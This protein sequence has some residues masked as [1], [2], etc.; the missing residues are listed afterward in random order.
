[1]GPWQK[2]EGLCPQK[3]L[4]IPSRQQHQHEQLSQTD[5]E[6]SKICQC[7]FMPTPSNK[8]KKLPNYDTH[9]EHHFFMPNHFKKGQIS[10][11]WP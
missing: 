10:G 8:A 6:V 11:I 1:M 4:L 7:F 5:R 2:R 3:K 9:A